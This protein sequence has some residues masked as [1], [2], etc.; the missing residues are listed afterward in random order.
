VYQREICWF[1][2]TGITDI[3]TDIADVVNIAGIA[4]WIL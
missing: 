4:D 2:F 1:V 3:I